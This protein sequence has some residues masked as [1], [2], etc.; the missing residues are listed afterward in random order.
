[1]SNYD[2]RESANDDSTITTIY[3]KDSSYLSFFL[4]IVPIFGFICLLPIFFIISGP[5]IHD[6]SVVFM[7][8]LSAFVLLTLINAYRTLFFT[9]VQYH[10]TF[11]QFKGFTHTLF[12]HKN[13][14]NINYSDIVEAYTFKPSGYLYTTFW[15]LL[16]KKI[17]G[18]TIKFNISIF[19]RNE[20]LILL[21]QHMVNQLSN[22]PVNELHTFSINIENEPKTF[23]TGRY[24]KLDIY[25]NNTDK[26]NIVTS[27]I[28]LHIHIGDILTLIGNNRAHIFRIQDYPRATYKIQET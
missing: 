9:K 13:I 17:D 3:P 2:E 5:G 21:H 19:N 10:E 1:M 7:L 27:N 11:I 6:G 12:P 16:I 20:V 26:L 25:I 4:L 8:I 18:T 23:W 14:T 15:L 22:N 28:T 24:R